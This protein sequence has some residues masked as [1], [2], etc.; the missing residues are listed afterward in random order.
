MLVFAGLRGPDLRFPPT[1]PR[2]PRQDRLVVCFSFLAQLILG[3]IEKMLLLHYFTLTSDARLEF[4][5]IQALRLKC[6][7]IER[8]GQ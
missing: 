5:E 4:F 2:V 6:V 8:A 7:S 1:K 3:E